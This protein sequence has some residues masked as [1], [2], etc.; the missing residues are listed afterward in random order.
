M[1]LLERI[2]GVGLLSALF[3]VLFAMAAMAED[4]TLDQAVC[5]G[6]A[7]G[8]GSSAIVGGVWSGGSSVCD[9]TS[10]TVDAGDSLT[11]PGSATLNVASSVDVDGAFVNQGSINADEI[12]VASAASLANPGSITATTLFEI[13]G[14]VTN[15]GGITIEAGGA[16][17]VNGSLLNNGGISAFNAGLGVWG[18]LTNNGGATATNVGVWG[19]VDNYGN[20]K[21]LFELR[22]W[23]T[24][25]NHC[26]SLFTAGAIA[27]GSTT[28][29]CPNCPNTTAE[30]DANAAPG[31]DWHD[32]YMRSIGS[33]ED[34]DL[35]NA[36][37]S[38]ANVSAQTKR[39]V[40]F[41]GAILSGA[42]L[43]SS[44]M[45]DTSFRNADL[46]G[47]TLYSSSKTNVDFSGAKMDGV[48][49]SGSTQ[50]ELDFAGASL[51][52]ADFH[53]TGN[54]R[55]D[56]TGADMKGGNYLWARFEDATLANA[57]IQDVRFEN[58]WFQGADLTGARGTPATIA[59]AVWAG[60]TCPDGYVVPD[61]EGTEETCEGHFLPLAA[62]EPSTTT[63]IAAAPASTAAPTTT[64]V[65]AAASESTL[66]FTGPS[67]NAPLA[68]AAAALV[69]VGLATV[70]GASDRRRNE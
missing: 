33:W 64:A 60:A 50:H 58:T 2:A 20:F 29:L 24:F 66:P 63:T 15:E 37:L 38:G 46:T 23:G 59:G 25:T 10:V 26:G 61:E 42:L 39:N 7:W 16:L 22:V 6:G 1:K 62:P 5:E 49:I 31:V 56:F 68:L 57:V 45:Y 12:D 35:T 70:R 54:N 4:R 40:N 13:L 14:S 51:V 8:A 32:C 55:S 48:D 34:Y 44:S 69:L 17:E 65:V 36:N 28:D 27:Q 41:T 53:S 3:V 19:T 67:E 47:A 18:D 9:A 52:N 30:V 43:H 21:A 11:V